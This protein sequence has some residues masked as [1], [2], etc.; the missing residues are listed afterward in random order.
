MKTALG[1]V[2][3]A[4]RF[5]G[6]LIA[7]LSWTPAWRATTQP[8]F[9]PH[10]G[11]RRPAKTG[12]LCKNK[13]ASRCIP[14]D[15]D[16]SRKGNGEEREGLIGRASGSGGAATEHQRVP[17]GQ[18]DCETKPSLLSIRQTAARTLPCAKD[19]RR[20]KDQGAIVGKDDAS[21]CGLAGRVLDE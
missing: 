9:A 4:T 1:A 15:S 11:T 5:R 16:L 10:C 19:G 20:P 2:T 17:F 7:R 3:S 8:Q 12:P 6:F 14:N 13:D 21:A 18:R